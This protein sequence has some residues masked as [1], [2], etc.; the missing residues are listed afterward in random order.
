MS[1]KHIEVP[2]LIDWD[3][4][5]CATLFLGGCNLRCKFCHNSQLVLNPEQLKDVEYEQILAN[6]KE[7]RNFMN[8]VCITGGEPL[9]NGK[10]L[11]PFLEKIK[12]LEY[13]IKLDTNGTF[14]DTLKS[15]IDKNLIDYI[16]MDIKAPLTVKKYSYITGKRF[17]IEKLSS[18]Q[19][20]IDII[21]N[22]NI[23]YEFR[24]TTVPTFHTQNDIEEICKYAIQGSKKYVLQNFRS[25]DTLVKAKLCPDHGFTIDEMN[26]LAFIALKYIPVVKIRNI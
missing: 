13:K 24:T 15:Y 8:G 12:A 6:L 19:K 20:S 1:I 21:K 16:A 17:T 10:S 23:D 18:I 9:I 7:F 14:P 26:G 11:I 3:G 22:S 2:S 25:C 4:N 5:T